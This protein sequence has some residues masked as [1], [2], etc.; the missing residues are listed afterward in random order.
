MIKADEIACYYGS[1]KVLDRI[2]L[3]T[4]EGELLGIVGPNGSGKTSLIKCMSGILK[5]KAGSVLIDEKNIFTC[6]AREIAKQAAVVPQDSNIAFSFTALETVLMGRTPH[7]GRFESESTGDMDIALWAM[8][9][10]HMRHLADR[11]V[12]E[13]SGGERQ[14]VII[15]RALAQQSKVMFLDEPTANL[16]INHKIEIL[17]LLKRLCQREGFIV[18]VAIHDL[19]MAAQYCDSLV[20][21]DNGRI[22]DMGTPEKVLTSDNIENVFNIKVMVKRHP[23]T[24]FLNITSLPTDTRAADKRD[25]SIHVICG[26]GTGSETVHFLCR[27]GYGVS[28]GVL[29]ALDSDYE[30][31]QSLGIPVISEAPFSPITDASHAANLGLIAQADAI[32]ITDTPVGHGNLKNVEA[33]KY[34]LER[35]KPLL[36]LKPFDGIQDKYGINPDIFDDLIEM[37][38][39]NVGSHGNLLSLVMRFEKSK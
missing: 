18:I 15:S 35:K 5:P 7:L 8:E 6:K 24:G 10:T 34:A 28:T 2:D 26:G 37:G 31:A 30:S 13:L 27:L 16:D 39:I 1:N 36:I 11:P 19:N 23:A 3:T 20:M 12:N 38:A 33:A 14:R 9:M 17:D 29:N 25:F 21:L 22:A 4:E 32:I